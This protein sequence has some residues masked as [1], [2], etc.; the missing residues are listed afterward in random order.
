[1]VFVNV[2][3]SRRVDFVSSDKRQI[4]SRAA[5]LLADELP[6]DHFPDRMLLA[7]FANVF[8]GLLAGHKGSAF[9]GR[10]ALQPDLVVAAIEDFRLMLRFAQF[11]F[12]RQALALC[13]LQRL[14]LLPGGLDAQLDGRREGLGGLIEKLAG[15]FCIGRAE[16]LLQGQ[17]HLVQDRVARMPIAC[18]P[19]VQTHRPERKIGRVQLGVSTLGDFLAEFLDRLVEARDEMG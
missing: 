5:K 1:L 16:P 12:G 18:L 2:A 7:L 8:A 17:T 11:R 10:A 14:E 15:S 4:A 13:A 19:S 9:A 3:Q 6:V